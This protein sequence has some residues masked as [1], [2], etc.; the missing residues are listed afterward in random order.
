VY[1]PANQVSFQGEFDS[2]IKIPVIQKGKGGFPYR[3]RSL[4]SNKKSQGKI[5][6]TSLIITPSGR[7][8][9]I[10]TIKKEKSFQN[11]LFPY[12]TP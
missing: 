11:S 3:G 1:Q 8:R 10:K 6:R 7:D 2:K 9:I 4:I 12:R 5:S